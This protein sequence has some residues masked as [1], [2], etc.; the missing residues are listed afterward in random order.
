MFRYATIAHWRPII[1]A[2]QLL[3]A[4]KGV[5]GVWVYETK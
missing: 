4:I 2:V 5:G 1:I 3:L